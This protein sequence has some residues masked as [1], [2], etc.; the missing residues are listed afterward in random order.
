M[1]IPPVSDGLVPPLNAPPAGLVYPG[2]Q[3]GVTSAIV[4]AHFV[5]VFGT[6]GGVF[7]YSGT[8]GP[9]TLI[10]SVTAA[11][12]DP[13]GNPTGQGITAYGSD[14]SYAELTEQGG[15]ALLL[16]EPPSRAHGASPGFPPQVLSAL[17]NGGAVNEYSYL[18]MSSGAETG[19]P[20]GQMVLGLTSE[21]DDASLAASFE[22]VAPGNDRLLFGNASGFSPGKATILGWLPVNQTDTTQHSVIASSFGLLSNAYNIVSGDANS[23]DV[24]RLTVCGNGSQGA[25]V[26]T[27]SFTAIMFGV[28]AGTVTVGG[29]AFTA[30]ADFS[31]RVTCEVTILTSGAAGTAFVAVSGVIGEFGAN[32]SS[33]NGNSGVFISQNSSVAVNTTA[34][35]T[36]S[37]A[38]EWGSMTDS[39]EITS[40]WSTLERLG[41]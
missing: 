32:Q 15:T 35:T 8:P 38:A 13:Y 33:S 22:I 34:A 27:L 2:V 12:A 11:S 21:A 19:E 26:N 1:T 20:D 39:P 3:P 14:G 23:G 37:L 29:T 4:L 24:Y 5:I 17:G 7:V 36:M 30:S 31:W 9:G 10:A 6:S 16:L 18:F 40:Y 28:E 41:P 25:V